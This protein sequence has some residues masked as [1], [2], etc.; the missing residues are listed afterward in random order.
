MKPVGTEIGFEFTLYRVT[1]ADPQVVHRGRAVI[2]GNKDYSVWPCPG[3]TVRV[4]ESP[5]YSTG[6]IVHLNPGS[7]R[8]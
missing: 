6:E 3:Y 4:T 2:V 8:P 5:D 7:V 1:L